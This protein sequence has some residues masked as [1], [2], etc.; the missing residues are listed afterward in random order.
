MKKRLRLN[1]VTL[2]NLSDEQVSMIGGG[3]SLADTCV[4]SCVV[5]QCHT[6][7]TCPPCLIGPT[8]DSCTSDQSTCAPANTCTVAC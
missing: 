1:K 2:K 7:H 5:T 8:V 4:R 6:P 3:A